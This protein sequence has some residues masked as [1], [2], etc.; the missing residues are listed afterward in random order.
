ME[1]LKEQTVLEKMFHLYSNKNRDEKQMCDE[2][3]HYAKNRIANC[4]Y[5]PNKP[6][7]S[8]CPTHCYT[9]DKKEQIKKIMRFSGPR[10]ILYHPVIA[11]R[12]I[13]QSKGVKTSLS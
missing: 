3:L 7:C 12:H 9:P 5:Q 8:A 13:F 10:M 1:I 2:L 11:I 4:P 6:F